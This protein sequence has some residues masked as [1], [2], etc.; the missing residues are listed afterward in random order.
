MFIE[1]RVSNYRSI[2]DEQCLSL[3]AS[4]D[5]SHSG[6]VV[7]SR[8]PATPKA[9]KSAVIYGAN[10]SGKSN[11]INAMAFM[12]AMV[13]DSA[14]QLKEGQPLN[15]Q[16]FKLDGEHPGQPSLFEA[17]F[18][19]DNIRYQYGFTVTADKVLQE[20][21]LAYKTS[22]PQQW[23]NR[24]WDETESR[25][26]YKFSASLTGPRSTWEEAT[27][28]NAL[29]LSTAV[30][31]NSEVLRP[32]FLWFTQK[33]VVFS[34]A[35]AGTLPHDFTNRMLQDEQYRDKITGFL[36]SADF[37]IDTVTIN[38]QKGFRQT[39]VFNGPDKASQSTSEQEVFIPVFRHT[40]NG[41]SSEFQI[42]EESQGTQRIYAMAGPIFEVLSGGLTFIVDELDSS[43]HPLMMR[44]LLDLFHDEESNA[45]GAQL[46]FTTHDTTL[47]D[48]DILRRD[49]I[50]FIEK[51]R[52]QASHLYPL[53]DFSPRKKE[54]LER[55]YLSGRYG[56]LPF[57]EHKQ[58]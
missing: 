31:L 23:F 26:H 18:V 48:T 33:L 54:A 6:H 57:L 28:N 45:H 56:A 34:N 50:W 10:A 7:D 58:A 32:V 39:I 12:K 15:C 30:Q 1:F 38:R 9:L 44:H 49:Q 4:P 29:F 11:I 55:G 43:L 27:R 5:K 52:Q 53:I 13:T 37:G 36:R 51:D 3:T 40:A 14:T 16:P 21:L 35:T 24:Q 19:H 17:T 22:K 2:R 41:V 20:W 42:H 46:I 25:Y 8:A 47:L